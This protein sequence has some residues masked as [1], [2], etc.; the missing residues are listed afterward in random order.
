MVI[1]ALSCH[2]NSQGR[3]FTMVNVQSP[4][5]SFA[6]QFSAGVNTLSF[7]GS[8]D[9][10]ASSLSHSTNARTAGRCRASGFVTA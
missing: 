7:Q 5:P 4:S 9:A 10:R 3:L 2:K 6:G 1:T 8:L